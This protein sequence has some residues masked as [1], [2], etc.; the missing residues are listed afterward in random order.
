ME[1]DRFLDIAVHG[2][3]QNLSFGLGRIVG[4]RAKGAF[5]PAERGNFFYVFCPNTFVFVNTPR[6]AKLFFLPLHIDPGM[7]PCVRT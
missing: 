2:S 5:S 1:I 7:R 4:E 6:V 3:A